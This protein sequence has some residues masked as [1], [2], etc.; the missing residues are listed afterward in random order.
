MCLCLSFVM[1][2]DTYGWSKQKYA[3][4]LECAR[5][6]RLD[7][8]DPGIFIRCYGQLMEISERAK[9][10]GAA[11]SVC[12]PNIELR[13]WQ[14]ECLRVIESEPDDRSI[15]FVCD[16]PGNC[17]KST[18]CKYLSRYPL[19]G[20][21]RDRDGGEPI[22]KQLRCQILSPGRGVDLARHLKPGDVYVLDCP[23]DDNAYIPWGFLEALKNGCIIS[24]KYDVLAK[25]QPSPHVF[26]FM[27]V[28]VPDY[29]L[30]VD[31]IKLIKPTYESS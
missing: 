12:C 18:F 16:T 20:L 2:A 6:G 4:A 15:Y 19:T 10:D 28:P 5:S 8:I 24:T 11:S 23:R 27:N 13:A 7:E 30:S 1:L 14:L 25:N 21:R 31:R 22:S 29:V 26:V 9:W 3:L 17:G